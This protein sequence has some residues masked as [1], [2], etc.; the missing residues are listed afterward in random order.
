MFLL[1][2]YNPNSLEVKE[3]KYKFI[4]SDEFWND[5]EYEIWIYFLCHY[6]P[7]SKLILCQI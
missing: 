4:N 6:R 3:V 2:L 7:H 5:Q 1:I